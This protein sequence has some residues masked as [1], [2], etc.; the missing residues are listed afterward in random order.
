MKQIPIEASLSSLLCGRGW[1]L[2]TAE[3]CTG[4]L[5]SK[6]ITDV[7]GSSEYFAGSLTAYCNAAKVS[8]L[9]VSEADLDQYGA[10]SSQVAKEMA[11]GALNRFSADIALSTTGI[12]GPGG[13]TED[14][15][16]GLVYIG[17][18]VR[19]KAPR[20]QAFQF[21]GNR[22][23]VRMAASQAALE[24]LQNELTS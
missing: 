17:L 9:G 22:T 12:A 8:M 15:P 24:M 3:S 7:A 4:G 13:G 18:A 14:K 21:K 5:I 11:V 10:V 16:V 2:A 6:R 20:A 23:D 1:L 19:D